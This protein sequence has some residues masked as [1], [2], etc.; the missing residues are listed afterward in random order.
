M[1]SIRLLSMVYGA[2][3]VGAGRFTAVKAISGL[4]GWVVRAEMSIEQAGPHWNKGIAAG[5]LNVVHTEGKEPRLVL[6]IAQCAG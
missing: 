1:P 5:K 2:R 3:L 4:N 6:D